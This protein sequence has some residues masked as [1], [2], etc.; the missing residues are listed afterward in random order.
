MFHD[1]IRTLPV[2]D[3][4]AYERLAGI[5]V[6][7]G[8]LGSAV[9]S[10]D[11]GALGESESETAFLR[12]FFA[13]VATS[14]AASSS[15]TAGSSSDASFARDDDDSDALRF[16]LAGDVEEED[17]AGLSAALRL[18]ARRAT[19][20][21]GVA[22]GAIVLRFD[23]EDGRSAEVKVGLARRTRNEDRAGAVERRTTKGLSIPLISLSFWL[24]VMRLPVTSSHTCKLSYSQDLKSVHRN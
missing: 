24:V 17:A 23:V 20:L 5:S 22:A 21:V 6:F 8:K 14:E 13:G 10:S 19:V 7:L 1:V 11:L 12:G 15:C 4:R 2:V 3:G 18:E 16:G 9:V